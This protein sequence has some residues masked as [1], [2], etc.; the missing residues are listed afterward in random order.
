MKKNRHKEGNRNLSREMEG[1]NPTYARPLRILF[2]LE[3]YP[4]HV[5]G[6]ETLFRDLAAGLV[7]AGHSCEVVTARLAGTP[8]YEERDGVKIHRVRV[9]KKGDRHWFTFFALPLCLKLA[10]EADVIHT[11]TYNAA[12]PAW[13]AARMRRKPALI[14]VHEV[15]GRSWKDLGFSPALSSL[16]RFLEALVLALPFDAYPANSRATFKAL[17]RSGVGLSRLRLVYPGVDR[18][19]FSAPPKI[20]R[21]RIREALEIPHDAPVAL[22][23]G[24]PGHA[25]GVHVLVKAAALVREA[26]PD[27][28]LLLVLSPDPP[29][30]FK[31]VKALADALPPGLAFI[32]PPV[33]RGLLP[34]L[35][36]ASD[37][38]CVPS[39]TEGF[40]FTC[41]ESCAARVPVVATCA[42]SIPEVISGAFMLVP[43]DSPQA[44][45][46]GIVKALLGRSLKSPLKHFDS[47]S[48]VT[49]HV[50]LYR[51]LCP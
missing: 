21:R 19:L 8:V 31:R 42:G 25:K 44:L 40:G 37:V 14:L 48:M 28:R 34:S 30:G 46:V 9:P 17:A 20:P 29:A 41:A 5:G 27:F 12:L 35:L 38:V 43:P 3:Y 18:S 45:A 50:G 23:F 10:R 13:L 2:I 7:A 33:D 49:A 15:L 39:L 36:A 1:R 11:M 22:Y 4:P 24:R 16:Y 47:A 51:R 26:L 32:I 6:G